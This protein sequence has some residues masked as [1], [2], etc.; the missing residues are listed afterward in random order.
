MVL[1]LCDGDLLKYLEKTEKGFSV[2]EIKVIFKQLNN[3]LSEIRSKNMAHNDLKLEN[4]LIKFKNNSNEFDIK[5]TNYGLGKFISDT[6]DLTKNEW[7]LVPYTDEKKE[8]L[9]IIK[10]VDLLILGLDIYRMLF[11]GLC[12]SFEEYINNIEN[13]IDDNDL[14]YLLKRTIVEDLH[15]RIE[16]DEFFNHPFFKKDKIDFSKTKNIVKI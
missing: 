2:Y 1:D 9:Y 16:W 5:L 7:G 13:F 11:K 8:N 4:I 6:K 14:K 12:Q 10:K 3:I 15:K